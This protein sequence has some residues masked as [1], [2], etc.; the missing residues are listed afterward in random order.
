[1]KRGY[2]NS[3]YLFIFKK[4]DKSKIIPIEIA[5]VRQNSTLEYT[6]S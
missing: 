3:I 2:E 1:M 4:A 5:G 6:T